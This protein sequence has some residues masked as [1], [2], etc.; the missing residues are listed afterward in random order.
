VRLTTTLSRLSL[1]I[2]ILA[3]AVL[4]GCASVPMATKEQ[5]ASAKAFSIP[6]PDKAGLYI[7]RDSFV[8]QALRKVVSIDGKVVGTT[9][10]K[11]YFFLELAPGSHTLT[12]ESEFGDNS[13]VLQASGGTNYYVR[14]Y[15]KMGVFVGG[16]ALEMVSEEDGKKAILTCERAQAQ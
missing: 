3:L 4:A 9:A 10:N 6:A 12:T 8:G 13:L 14:Q 16:S 1:F 11:T 2:L 5:D 15:I 7:Y